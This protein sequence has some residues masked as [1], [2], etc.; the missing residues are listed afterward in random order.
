MPRPMEP[1]DRMAIVGLGSGEDMAGLV[2][3]WL[4][5]MSLTGLENDVDISCY[6][7]LFCDYIQQ[8]AMAW[9][10]GV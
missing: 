5:G 3:W 6:M 7:E 9:D 2:W 8:F 1:M 10:G 4:G